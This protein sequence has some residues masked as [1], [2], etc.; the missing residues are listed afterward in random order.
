MKIV[1]FTFYYPPDLCAGSFRS[2]ALVKALSVKVDAETEIH[3]ITTHPN[4]YA[5]YEVEEIVEDNVVEGNVHIHRIRIP[6]HKSGMFSQVRSFFVYSARAFYYC[7]K[8][9]PDFIIGTTSR[10]M[11]GVLTWLSATILGRRYLIDLRDIFSET[12]SDVFA[13]KNRLLGSVAKSIFSLIEKRV[14]KNA[15]SV[16]VV[17]LG[18]PEYFK[19]QGIPTSNWT[20][21]PNGVDDEF[22]NLPRLVEARQTNKKTILYAGNIGSGQGLELIIPQVAK[23]L[24][25]QY[26]FVVIG[27]GGTKHTLEAMLVS[28][29]V[30][31]VDLLPP[32]ARGE[33]I[34]Y[35]ESA[36]VLFLHLNDLPA[37]KRVLPSKIFEYAALGKPVIAGLEGYSAQFVKDYLKY[38][39]VFSPGDA[40]A[41][42]TCIENTSVDEN[43]VQAVNEFVTKFSRMQIMDD[44]SDHIISVL[45]GVAAGAK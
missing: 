16:N 35:Y 25:E 3:V 9:K 39:C 21:F 15:A 29:G 22:I 17:S 45:S 32:V 10:L 36:D 41:C 12:I 33:L 1:F 44:M 11:T 40:D 20:F 8:I 23:K 27:D 18:F 42:V 24:G 5:T 6:A 13:L 43:A 34:K 4:R 7:A 38:G 28:E 14:F 30:K 37:F 2:V 19:S 26:R 31:N